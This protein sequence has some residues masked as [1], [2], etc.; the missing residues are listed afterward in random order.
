MSAVD[1]VQSA[2]LAVSL[3]LSG[4]SLM[5]RRRISGVA[6][7]PDHP[8]EELLSEMLAKSRASGGRIH[9][10]DAEEIIRRRLG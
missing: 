1:I 6:P 7:R 9:I 5:T 2:V 8:V 4:W 3:V 10:H